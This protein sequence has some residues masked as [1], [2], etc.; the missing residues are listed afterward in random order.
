MESVESWETEGQKVKIGEESERRVTATVCRL[1]WERTPARNRLARRTVRL[2]RAH[3]AMCA[4]MA[5]RSLGTMCSACRFPSF[6]CYRACL[7]F[8][9]L[10]INNSRQYL[11]ISLCVPGTVLSTFLK[12]THLTLLMTQSN[13]YLYSKGVTK[14]LHSCVGLY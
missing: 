4:Q 14:R 2:Q 5:C 13:R 7:Y 10:L 3:T 11:F 8:M 12:Y 1:R 9:L 6:D